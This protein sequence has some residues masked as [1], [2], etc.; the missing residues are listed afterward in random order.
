[1]VG[2]LLDSVGTE[3]CARLMRTLVSCLFVVS[4][5]LHVSFGGYGY[6]KYGS[7]KDKGAEVVLLAIAGAHFGVNA[8][9][10]GYFLGHHGRGHHGKKHETIV[11]G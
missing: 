3:M 1:M 9:M 11:I 6:G 2:L 10:G 8:L 5:L 4:L 7:K